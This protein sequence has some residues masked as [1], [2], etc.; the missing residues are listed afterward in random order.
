M[1][2]SDGSVKSLELWNDGPAVQATLGQMQQFQVQ[3]QRQLQ[4]QVEQMQLLMGS[5]P[6]SSQ[7][8]Q[9]QPQQAYGFPIPIWPQQP[10][11]MMPFF[12]PTE[13]PKLQK[14]N[15]KRAK[16]RAGRLG[17]RERAEM[18]ASRSGSA[19]PTGDPKSELSEE[20]PG[21]DD[22]LIAGK[23]DVATKG[24]KVEVQAVQEHLDEFARALK[25]DFVETRKTFLED[26]QKI[27]S[28]A[29]HVKDWIDENHEQN[30]HMLMQTKTELQEFMVEH[31]KATITNAITEVQKEGLALK[32]DFVSSCNTFLE[33]AQKMTTSSAAHVRDWIEEN[34]QQNE[35]MVMQMKTELQEFMVE[36][37]K[38]AITN[39]IT[40]VQKRGLRELSAQIQLANANAQQA[41]EKDCKEIVSQAG[42]AL[43]DLS[44]NVTDKLRNTS[45]KLDILAGSLNELKA[46]MAS[47]HEY[48]SAEDRET[49]KQ[50]IALPETRT[51]TIASQDAMTQVDQEASRS[52][53]KASASACQIRS[54]P[55]VGSVLDRFSSLHKAPGIILTESDTLVSCVD[56]FDSWKT[57]YGKVAVTTGQHQWNVE[58]VCAQRLYNYPWQMIIGVGMEPMEPFKCAESLWS[59]GFGYILS[60]KKT[61]RNGQ[62]EK[63][64]SA[65]NDG[66]VVSV[67]LDMTKLCL[68]FKKNGK[69]LG[70]SHSI[71]RGSYHLAVSMWGHNETVKLRH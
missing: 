20:E 28:S 9:A 47:I 64:A 4:E 37:T 34:H 55:A 30:E 42:N 56:W 53:C 67:V 38:V 11:S 71:P 19:L 51:Q 10:P 3:M 12:P 58:V 49:R 68:S 69:D 2:M 50:A 59:T 26:A 52:S 27:T 39:A 48:I 17:K 70:V 44:V 5:L 57:V 15:S 18:R 21:S 65:Y 6:Q 41:L 32:A 36:H 35:H 22:W 54:F 29:A 25:A 61:T 45:S 1:T 46:D 8:A 33:D 62:P 31:T 7:P 43:T 13:F 24:G 63:Y 40:E 66:D 60:G 23:P 16:I 14:T